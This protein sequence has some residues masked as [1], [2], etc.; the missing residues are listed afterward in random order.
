MKNRSSKSNSLAIQFRNTTKQKGFFVCLILILTLSAVYLFS[1]DLGVQPVYAGSTL[2]PT[3]P[4]TNTPEATATP[5]PPTNTPTVPS[6]ADT[7]VPTNTPVP[8]PPTS[9]PRPSSGGSNN[10]PPTEVPTVV[11]T[12]TNLPV[13]EIPELGVGD[14][15][16]F[17]LITAIGIMILLM[18][19]GS[20]ITKANQNA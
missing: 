5:I 4:P 1:T 3:S 16:N 12:A 7:E 19:L 14:N 20:L 17:L 18:W 15:I 10:Q 8:P 6:P 2:T 11:P 13:Q 9:T